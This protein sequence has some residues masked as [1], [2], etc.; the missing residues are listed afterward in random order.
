MK[1]N[2]RLIE[3]QAAL[4]APKNQS[5]QGLHY[6]Y[7]NCDAILEAV[8]PLCKE[9]GLLL[10]LS[11]SIEAHATRV[12]VKATATV[13]DGENTVSVSA[14]ARETLSRS[15]LDDAQVTGGASSYARKYA[16][17]GLFCI[18]NTD[19]PDGMDN[20]KPKPEPKKNPAKDKP[21]T[22]T[23]LDYEVAYQECINLS[24][25]QKR[26]QIDYKENPADRGDMEKAKNIR[27]KELSNG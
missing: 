27:K 9:Q 8:K 21:P 24:D 22:Q 4:H 17:S 19:D 26:Y 12:Y 7:R 13:S 14:F 18:D 5:K 15:G 3:V 10:T 20:S 16:L 1:I 23:Q 25:L 2:E 6:K 11:D